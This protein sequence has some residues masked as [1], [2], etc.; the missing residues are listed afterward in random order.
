MDIF[1]V[2]ATPRPETLADLNRYLVDKI[3]ALFGMLKAW[4]DELSL[5]KQEGPR[6]EGAFVEDVRGFMIPE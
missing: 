1:M 3:P 2:N 5:H 6:M 4:E